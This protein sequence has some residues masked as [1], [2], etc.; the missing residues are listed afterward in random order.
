MAPAA[1]VQGLGQVGVG[2]FCE[3]EEVGVQGCLRL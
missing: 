1:E 3:V 2:C